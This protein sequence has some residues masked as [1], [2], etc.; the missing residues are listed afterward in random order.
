MRTTHARVGI[1]FIALALW[2]VGCAKADYIQIEPDIAILKT[3]NDSVW[4]RGHVRSN[5][6]TEYPKAVVS[7]SVKDPSVARVDDTGRLF[8]VKSGSTEVV[9]SYRGATAS[10]PV[11]VVFA[12]K[13]KVEPTLLQLNEDGDPVDI[14]VKVYDYLGRELR[15]RSPTFRSLDKAVLTMGQNAAHPGRAGST[16]VEVKVDELVQFVDVRVK[17][18]KQ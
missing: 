4:L 10:I 1:G 7:W 6:G 13:L 18:R 16:Q 12:E 11:E 9:A 14:R 2:A 17:K 5:T 3:K 8:P 15:D